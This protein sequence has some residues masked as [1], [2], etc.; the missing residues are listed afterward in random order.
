MNYQKCDSLNPEALKH[1][2]IISCTAL[3][4]RGYGNQTLFVIYLSGKISGV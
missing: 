1:F 3:D 4:T 2:K